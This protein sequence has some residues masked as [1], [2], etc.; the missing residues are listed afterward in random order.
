MQ[1]YSKLKYGKVFTI[2]MA[3][4]SDISSCFIFLLLLLLNAAFCSPVEGPD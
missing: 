1:E 3:F 4:C 2:E